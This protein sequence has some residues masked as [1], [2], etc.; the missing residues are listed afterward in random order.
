MP[1]ASGDSVSSQPL[2]AAG[3]GNDSGDCRRLVVANSLSELGHVSEWVRGFA[4]ERGLPHRLA[5]DLELAVN[6]ALTNIMSYAYRDDARHDIVIEL[7][8]QPDRVRIAVEDD[9]V[10]FNP[11]ERRMEEPPAS[12]EKARPDGRGILLMRR[13]MD[14]MHYLR[15]DN[16]NVLTMVLLHAET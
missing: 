5:H 1:R 3:T 14:E 8:A 16:R 2:S 10:A 6:E 4:H 7:H 11:L 12:L 9:G 13:V 15:R